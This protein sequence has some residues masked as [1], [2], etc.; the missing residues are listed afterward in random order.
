MGDR[1]EGSRAVDDARPRERR[2]QRHV[3]VAQTSVLRRSTVPNLAVASFATCFLACAGTPALHT[4]RTTPIPTNADG[5]AK[6]VFLWPSDNCEPGG[7]FSIAS[8]SGRF[9]GNVARGTRLEVDMPE[10]AETFFAWNPPREEAAASAVSENVAILRVELFAGRTYFARLA[11]GEWDERGPR[12]L[13]GGDHRRRGVVY[14]A[15]VSANLALLALPPRSSE[16]SSLHDWLD[17]LTPIA[18]E[19]SPGQAWLDAESW[20]VPEH[21]ALAERRWLH[22]TAEARRLASLD[23]TDGVRVEP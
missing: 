22:M 1:T 14:R 12:I 13:Y 16:W 8:S 10:G 18:P 3:P 11:F 23:G 5:L 9:V 15:C 21:R 2:R 4:T 7:H 6:V 20:Q 17:T 19:L